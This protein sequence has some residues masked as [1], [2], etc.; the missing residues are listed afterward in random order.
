MQGFL[1]AGIIVLVKESRDETKYGQNSRSLFVRK[2][3]SVGE[4]YFHNF[5]AN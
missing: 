3:T 4:K 5:F 2:K 1:V